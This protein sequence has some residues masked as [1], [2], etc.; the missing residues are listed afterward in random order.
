MKNPKQKIQA[1]LA[2]SKSDGTPVMER[3]SES[4]KGAVSERFGNLR[5]LGM[6]LGLLFL[7]LIGTLAIRSAGSPEPVPSSSATM[8]T[9]PAESG[10]AATPIVQPDAM[11]DT[12]QGGYAVGIDSYPLM[13][14]PAEFETR[15]PGNLMPGQRSPEEIERIYRKMGEQMPDGVTLNG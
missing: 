5:L 13:D 2:A 6:S 3:L 7:C 1:L 12:M 15:R 14:Q 4:R 11:Q 9:A 10:I 8:T